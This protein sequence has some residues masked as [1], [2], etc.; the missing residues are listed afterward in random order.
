MHQ[1]FTKTLRLKQKLLSAG[2]HEEKKKK[3]CD[4]LTQQL[5]TCSVMMC[6][7]LKMHAHPCCHQK[8]MTIQ[9]QISSRYVAA[10]YITVGKTYHQVLNC[11]PNFQ[12]A[13]DFYS[14]Q[15]CMKLYVH[16]S[17]PSLGFFLVI[18][19]LRVIC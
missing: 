15:L 9:T 3:K 1:T 14:L 5:V 19:D 2:E 6:Q 8:F 11:F 12:A 16:Q 13:T 17:L 4:S 18:N 10:H 7:L